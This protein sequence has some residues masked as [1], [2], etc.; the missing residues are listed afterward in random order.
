[1]QTNV[2]I[3]LASDYGDTLYPFFGGYVDICDLINTQDR[4]SKN[5]MTLKVKGR[6]YGQ[7]LQNLTCWGSDVGH[8]ENLVYNLLVYGASG[9]LAGNTTSLSTN[10]PSNPYSEISY[11]VPS[12]LLSAGTIQWSSNGRDYIGNSITSLLKVANWDGYTDPNKNWK[13]F[14]VGS[15]SSGITLYEYNNDSR[16]NIIGPIHSQPCDGTELRNVII[17]Y[18]GSVADSW[19]D[20]GIMSLPN[21][22][23]AESNAQTPVEFAGGGT[24]I[25]GVTYDLPQAGACSIKVA[26]VDNSYNAI[27]WGMNFPNFFHWY[28]P[29]NQ[30]AQGTMKWSLYHYY[31]TGTNYPNSVITPANSGFRNGDMLLN[32]P[33]VSLMDTCGNVITYI[34]NSND[35]GF[36][37]TAAGY[38]FNHWITLSVTVGWAVT[39]DAQVW[40]Q[41][42]GH[43]TNVPIWADAREKWLY[44]AWTDQGI[45][46]PSS[47]SAQSG[48]SPNNRTGYF[49]YTGVSQ[50]QG[51]YWWGGSSWILKDSTVTNNGGFNWKV[52]NMTFQAA[53]SSLGGAPSYVLFDNLTLPQEIQV[54][55][56]A[57]HSGLNG[58]CKI[59]GNTYPPSPYR[60]RQLKVTKANL[61]Y[62]LDL[63]NYAETVALQR[64]GYVPKTPYTPPLSSSL[65]NYNSNV[66][67]TVS[68]RCDGR[69]GLVNGAWSWYPGLS[70]SLNDSES[71]RMIEI[72]HTIER[73]VEGSGFSHVV[74][75]KLVPKTF[76][77]D[78]E[79]WTYNQHGDVGISRQ[80]H[81][82]IEALENTYQLFNQQS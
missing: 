69:A 26:C 76:Q 36:L 73:N 24:I 21:T 49:I 62:Q 46:L 60:Q 53:Q 17:A 51:L 57:D 32:Q 58:P 67:S 11:A 13:M 80:L 39:T 6:D 14:P 20:T 15:V 59:C 55:A 82:R 7:D 70:L 34:F 12:P 22:W 38:L 56:V 64:G 16:N 44:T 79:Q 4:S 65:S 47:P 42:T 8:I 72:A 29:F 78:M 31:P 25:N 43:G 77:L 52:I 81:Q 37:G 28:I 48:S 27:T 18:G 3:N 35:Y 2:S 63:Q 66:L 1:V 74:D 71:W 19:T 41:G 5:I 50:S 54:V 30:I 9:I 61:N 45:A 23:I 10:S 75:L 68:L 40:S 33:A